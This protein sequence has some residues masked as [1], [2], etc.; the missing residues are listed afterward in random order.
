MTGNWD[1]CV[2]RNTPRSRLSG[3]VARRHHAVEEG[4]CWSCQLFLEHGKPSA[5]SGCGFFSMSL[6]PAEPTPGISCLC[7][8]FLGDGMGL[9]LSASVFILCFMGVVDTQIAPCVVT[10]HCRNKYPRLSAY[11]RS[12]FSSEFW[13]FLSMMD[14][15]CLQWGSKRI[16]RSAQWDQVVICPGCRRRDEASIPLFCLIKGESPGP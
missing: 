16:T 5:A 7:E 10:L 6:S 13:R 2:I 14:W 12:S 1:S 15:W 3:S 11:K 8:V 9:C 4:L